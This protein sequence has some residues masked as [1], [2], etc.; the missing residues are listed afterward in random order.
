MYEF[1]CK[2]IGNS[3]QRISFRFLYLIVVISGHLAHTWGTFD[4]EWKCLFGSGTN[5][6]KCFFCYRR[7]IRFLQREALTNWPVDRNCGMWNV[8]AYVSRK[9]CGLV[10]I[11]QSSEGRCGGGQMM[12][13]HRTAPMTSP[14]KPTTYTSETVAV[15]M[16]SCTV[17]TS[18]VC[19]MCSFVSEAQ[20]H[21]RLTKWFY[22]K[23]LPCSM[24]T[25]YWVWVWANHSS[26]SWTSPIRAMPFSAFAHRACWGRP[27]LRPKNVASS[28]VAW[29][30]SDPVSAVVSARSV[31]HWI[32]VCFRHRMNPCY[33]CGSRA[34]SSLSIFMLL[35]FFSSVEAA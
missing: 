6:E 25:P 2:Y 33:W 26:T 5:S 4:T 34:F 3:T 14:P 32:V 13:N 24:E 15:D 20:C 12:M 23:H 9:S 21:M 22:K 29:H 19:V 11:S 27:V 31:A 28:P 18:C 1:N 35:L 8:V 7:P 10:H 30:R 16:H 17:Y